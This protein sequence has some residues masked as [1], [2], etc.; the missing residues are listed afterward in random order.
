MVLAIIK[1]KML[2]ILCFI[3]SALMKADCR[4]G[5][6]KL[7]CLGPGAVISILDLIWKSH[8]RTFNSVGFIIQKQHTIFVFAVLYK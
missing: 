5:K 6:S 8:D 7:H 3:D 2:F 1:K 4:L